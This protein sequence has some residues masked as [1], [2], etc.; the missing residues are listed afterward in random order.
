[1]SVQYV[2]ADCDA[3]TEA[4]L[5]RGYTRS[6]RSVKD[7]LGAGLYNQL[8]TETRASLTL[9]Q[10]DAEEHGKLNEPEVNSRPRWRH[11]S[12]LSSCHIERVQVLERGPWMSI[13]AP[14][15]ENGSSFN[16][17]GADECESLDLH[18]TSER[19][20]QSMERTINKEIE[21]HLDAVE[22]L[23]AFLRTP[24]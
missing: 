10:I 24:Q 16:E 18:L 22:Q 5:A 12:Y 23:R 6:E 21:R 1:V 11:D 15:R 20:R 8:S 9:L 19:C 13:V 14:V 2:I 3:V 17:A 4:Y 7:Q